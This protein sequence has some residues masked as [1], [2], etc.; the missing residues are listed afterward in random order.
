MFR[1]N[2]LRRPQVARVAVPE[3]GN[4]NL[5]STEGQAMDDNVRNGGF[6]VE[7]ILLVK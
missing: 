5:R 2:N 4:G 1:E 6:D 7:T 3:V